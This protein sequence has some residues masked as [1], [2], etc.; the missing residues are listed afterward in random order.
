VQRVPGAPC[1]I[2][3][4]VEI[5]THTNTHIFFDTRAARRTQGQV[6]RDAPLCAYIYEMKNGCENIAHKSWKY[7]EIQA[8]LQTHTHSTQC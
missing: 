1:H 8:A 3:K 6:R 2:P 7:Y 4:K 5:S